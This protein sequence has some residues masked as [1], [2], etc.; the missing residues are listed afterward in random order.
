MSKII[1]SIKIFF[2]IST[3]FFINS[4][5]QNDSKKIVAK[6]GEYEISKSE[7]IL[8]YE[9]YIIQTGIKDNFISRKDVINSMVSEIVLTKYDENKYIYDNDEFNTETKWLKDQAILA[10]LKDQEVYAKISA[11]DE[12]TRNAFLRS[13]EKLS[14]SHLFATTENEINELHQLLKVGVSFEELAKQIFTDS[15][16]QSNGGN[17]GFVEWGDLEPEFEDKAYSMRV[18]E[19]SR[20]VKT[21]HGYSIIK[22]NERVS[23]P[24]LTENEYQKRKSKFEHIIRLRKKKPTEKSYVNS[25]VDFESINFTEKS[26][27]EVWESI[28]LRI[29]RN[30]ELKQFKGND[31][32]CVEYKGKVYLTSE[33]IEKVNTIPSYHFEKVTSIKKLKT[34]IK[35][36]VLKDRLKEIADEKGYSNNKYVL[37]KFEKMKTN[38][39]MKYKISE[40]IEKSNIQ[41]S[42]I[43]DFYTKHPEFFSTHDEIN[44]QE[45]L[46]T[47]KKLANSLLKKIKSGANFG[48]LA[49]K[50]SKR[51]P[52]A[53]KFGILGFAPISKFGMLKDIF[54]ESKLNKIIGPLKIEQ[55]FGIFKVLD[56]K[57][58]KSISFEESKDIA[59]MAVKY[60][61]KN[62]ILSDYLEKLKSKI[63]IEIFDNVIGSTKIF[64]FANN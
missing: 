7:F 34:V 26:I 23:H 8:R 61:Q 35:G 53:S 25:I 59:E 10:Y 57:K 32:Q 12:E 11:N 27:E 41:D 54:W 42:V 6:I 28:Q 36:F 21:E 55:Y 60:K 50:Y 1:I 38:L 52:T 18:G 47:D 17:L 62:K 13:N 3:I 15:T 22:V 58:S 39:F 63:N 2:F 51:T 45:I 20:P 16:L 43:L 14:V 5:T 44:V 56:R 19:I 31:E 9:D 49:K 37:K 30:S 48:K 46:V 4:C 64:E 24:L 40:I 29:D 33:I